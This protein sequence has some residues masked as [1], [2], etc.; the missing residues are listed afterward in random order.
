MSS[1]RVT[2]CTA[3]ILILVSW[4]GY[5]VPRCEAQQTKR[6]FTVR[7]DIGMTTFHAPNGEAKPLQFSPD[8][9]YVAVYTDKGRL[10]LNHP[11][12]T[13]WFYQSSDV[14]NFL[15]LSRVANSPI[16]KA[17]WAVSCSGY[18]EGPNINKWQWLADS[19]GV[20]FLERTGPGNQRLVFADLRTKTT[21]TMT[22]GAEI[23]VDFDFRDRK[24]YVY[25][26]SDSA[27]LQRLETDRQSPAI[28]GT[29]RSLES[30]IAL[31]DPW[32][33][34]FKPS[35]LWAVVNG[36]RFEVRRNGDPIVPPF[37]YDFALSP[38]AHSLVT[39]L[40]VSEVPVSWE[41][42]YPP[43][44]PSSSSRIRAGIGPA[45]QYVLIHLQTGSVESL[46][47]A[48]TSN[49]AGWWTMGGPSWS[50]NG[51]AVVL[52]GTFVAT[53]AQMPSRPCVA[54][55]DLASHSRSCVEILKGKTDTGVEDG[56][57]FVKGS[58]FIDGDEHRVLVIFEDREGHWLNNKEYRS[59]SEGQ[60]QVVGEGKGEFAASPAGLE[61]EVRESFD[62]P[63]VLVAK[64]KDISREI[65]DPN[66]EFQNIDLGQASVYRWQDK[67]GRNWRGGLYKPSNYRAGQRYPLLIQTHHFYESM[68]IASGAFPSAYA[69]RELATAGILVLQVADEENCATV[70]PS[71]GPC[72][73]SGYESAVNQLVEE[74]VADPE[75]VGILGFSRTCFYVME[76]L[77]TS[78]LHIKAA[79]VTDGVMRTYL[80]YIGGQQKEADVMIG[81]PPFGEGLKLWLRRSPGFN[82]DKITAPLL[83][84]AKEGP[85]N[86]LYMWEPYAGLYS[87]HKPVDLIILNTHQHV[88]T[89]PAV[90]L[91]SQGGTVDWFR[92]WL[93]SYEDP[94]PAKGE[95]YRRWRDLRI[96]RTEH[97]K[98]ARTPKSASN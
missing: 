4:L 59:T 46:T 54:V 7:D 23:V 40:P 42:L 85:A 38:N 69:A 90:R 20:A 35:R 84:V 1:K 25:T 24:N 98:K 6:P 97:E 48:P 32:D 37:G 49:S 78:P 72:A 11:E 13:L 83:V 87:L 41:T 10:D 2:P 70:S 73:V 36:R 66:P 51:Q 14:E 74:G 92:F 52:P 61:L 79:S 17:V 81:A 27:Q 77:T 88:L 33:L 3:P 86:T 60:W 68:F 5:A 29:G 9:K 43:T 67:E 89:N 50:S 19:S 63:P 34:L 28:V 64:N 12:D 47:G 16:P 22:A 31:P 95:Q 75:N 93:Q 82:L 80:Q 44:F 21:A 94:D 39:V 15:S 96:M 76:T 45:W 56:Y 53:A 62:K 8:G 30:L 55:V 57:H 91:A 58:R 71:E 18:K 65:W 26:T